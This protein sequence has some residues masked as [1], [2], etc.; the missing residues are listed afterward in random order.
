MWINSNERQESF[1]HLWKM[2]P[3]IE[4]I[5]NIDPKDVKSEHLWFLDSHLKWLQ[6]QFPDI[7]K[8]IDITRKKIKIAMWL[9]ANMVPLE[10]MESANNPEYKNREYRSL[11]AA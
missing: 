6:V 11:D 8:E 3:K 5:T 4:T 10:I 2:P 7:A 9:W 1:S